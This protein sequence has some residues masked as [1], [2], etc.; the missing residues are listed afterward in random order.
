[1]ALDLRELIAQ[2]GAN[3]EETK[4]LVQALSE[5]R[6][7]LETERRKVGELQAENNALREADAGGQRYVGELIA[8]S[9]RRQLAID[10]FLA[11]VVRK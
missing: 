5:C 11:Q 4:K 9:Q 6:L 8:E 10:D 7:A 3:G 2:V 1:M